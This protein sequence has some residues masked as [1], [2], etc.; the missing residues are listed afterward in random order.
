MGLRPSLGAQA[1][2]S[3]RRLRW[4]GAETPVAPGGDSGLL[5]RRLR[6]GESRA[7]SPPILRPSSDWGPGALHRWCPRAL[8]RG[9][10][11]PVWRAGDSGVAGAETP[12]LRSG[13]SGIPASALAS[14]VFSFTS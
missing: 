9:P 7:D 12:V 11:T 14:F 2:H 10:E 5:G 13:D 4:K 8:P 6:S 1:S 3:G